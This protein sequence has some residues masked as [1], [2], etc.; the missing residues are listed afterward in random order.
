VVAGTA[1]VVGHAVYPVKEAVITTID[2]IQMCLHPH[3]AKKAEAHTQVPTFIVGNAA[4]RSR[5]D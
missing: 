5:N 4:P 2:N 1:T 3:L